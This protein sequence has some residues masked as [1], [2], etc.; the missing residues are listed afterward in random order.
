MD[1]AE[2]T[3]QLQTTETK[4]KN[5]IQ[6]FQFISKF[7]HSYNKMLG[8]KNPTGIASNNTIW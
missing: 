5:S 4:T 3:G 2:T 6:F 8:E 1:V 7:E